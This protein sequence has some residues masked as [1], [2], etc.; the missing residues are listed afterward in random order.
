MQLVDNEGG[1]WFN[2]LDVNLP[3]VEEHGVESGIERT[4][5]VGIQVVAN[6]QRGSTFGTSLAE[7]IVE[8]RL[9]GLVGTGIL[10]KDDGVKVVAEPTGFQ[11]LILHLMESVA[12]HVHAVALLLEGFHQLVGTLHHARLVGTEVQEAVA[13]LQTAGLGEVYSFAYRQRTAKAFHD[14][15]VARDFPSRIAAPQVNVS[16]PIGIVER[17]RVCE[18]AV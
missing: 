1:L 4:E 7:G 11:L 3:A 6:H 8:I 15:V 2:V 13:Y 14:K 9:G 17:L 16:L 12:G 5:D 10:A 18:I